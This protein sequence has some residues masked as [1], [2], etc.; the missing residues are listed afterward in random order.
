MSK[1]IPDEILV[2]I[3]NEIPIDVLISEVLKIPNKRS[4]GYFRFLCPIC[5]DF[6]TA[7]KKETNLGRC[8]SCN[9]NFNPIDIVMEYNELTF[10]DTV[11]F[12][13]PILN[14]FN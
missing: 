14:C 7:T 5:N 9:K 2:K 1:R 13:T 3:R 10:L 11:K 6:N 12:L 4:E 8:F